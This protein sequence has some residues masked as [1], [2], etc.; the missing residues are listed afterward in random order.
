ML[1]FLM[2]SCMEKQDFDQF[3]DLRLQPTYEASILYVEAPE[4]AIDAAA[5]VTFFTWDLNFDAFSENLFAER[6]R[7]AVITY[8]VENT[9]KKEFDI[10]VEFL[11]ETGNVLYTE[12]F[13]V[14]P[15]PTPIY[16]REIVFGSGGNNLDILRNT[17]GFRVS[18]EVGPNEST[19]D[20]PDPMVTLKSSGKFTMAIK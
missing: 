3:D 16:Q 11:D 18:A 8:E 4:Y 7:R 13:E 15:A 17:S 14:P 10:A 12:I 9:T 2:L 19:S 20:L 6:V 1:L 5:P